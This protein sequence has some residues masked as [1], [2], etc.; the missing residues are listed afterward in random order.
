M[1]KKFKLFEY[2]SHYHSLAGDFH[3]SD[4]LGISEFESE[5]IYNEVANFYRKNPDLSYLGSG[6]FGAAFSLDSER[7]LKITTDPTEVN[8]IEYLRKKNFAGIVSYYDLRKINLYINNK[9]CREEDIFSIIMDKVEPLNETELDCYQLLYR[10]GYIGPDAEILSFTYTLDYREIEE[11][12]AKHFKSYND[13]SRAKM[14][15]EIIMTSKNFDEYLQKMKTAIGDYYSFEYNNLY[16]LQNDVNF[17]EIFFKFYDDIRN[18]LADVIRYKL[19]LYDSHEKNVGKDK[20][21][22]FK[23]IDLGFRTNGPTRKL[24][25][26]PIDIRI[27]KEEE[28]QFTLLVSTDGINFTYNGIYDSIEEAIDDI[29]GDLD[30]KWIKIKGESFLIYHTKDKSGKDYFYRIVSNKENKEEFLKGRWQVKDPDQLSLKFP[31]TQ[32]SWKNL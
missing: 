10:I 26:K 4:K 23:M 17:K 30:E 14:I 29:D 2:I 3:L 8:N 5:K 11:R 16:D 22:H 28:E 31:K 24:K 7:V 27:E 12:S 9:Y 18:L 32:P 25:L 13:G 21:G 19:S 1:I 20:N 15:Y 6:S